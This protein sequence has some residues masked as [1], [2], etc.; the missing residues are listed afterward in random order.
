MRIGEESPVALIREEKV[1]VTS[2]CMYRSVLQ[3]FLGSTHLSALISY[4]ISM[5]QSVLSNSRRPLF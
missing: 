4:A 1:A 5:S 3:G 2:Y